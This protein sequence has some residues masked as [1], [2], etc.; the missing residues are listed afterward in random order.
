MLRRRFEA[1]TGIALATLALGACGEPDWVRVIGV[2]NVNP[3]RTITV[4]APTRV[5]A[6]TD[7]IVT[8][9]TFGSSNC[10]EANGAD[11]TTSGTVVR[12]VPYDR[13]PA[14]GSGVGCF[15][16][17]QG[18]GHTHGV[19]FTET[20]P[21]TLRVVGYFAGNT[22]QVLDSVEVELQVDP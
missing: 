2:L 11:V 14:P 5:S 22:E 1:I 17:L 20:G 9:T 16:N 15:R 10:T 8:V 13:V 19:Q 3:D 7:F 18:F 6:R 4:T 21:A 12:F